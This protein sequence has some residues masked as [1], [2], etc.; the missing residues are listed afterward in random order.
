MQYRH[1]TLFLLAM[2]AGSRVHAWSRMA[3]AR[4]YSINGQPC[5]TISN[6]EEARNGVPLLGALSVYDISSKPAEETWSF[7][8]PATITM[9]MSAR[10]CLLYGHAPAG[11]E[12]TV[13]IQLQKGRMYSVFLNGRPGDPSDPTYGYK[14][15]FCITS[16]ADGGQQVIVIT[17]EMPAWR[18]EVC[19]TA[20]SP[21]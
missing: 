8:F 10:S 15:K 1:T 13:A 4:V 9:P 2:L 5:F 16:K 11:S 20:S 12:A 3:D 18:H 7:I 19:A 17:R 14:G 6:K 21:Q